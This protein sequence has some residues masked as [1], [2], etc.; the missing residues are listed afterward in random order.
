MHRQ[1]V[2]HLHQQAKH[3]DFETWQQPKESEWILLIKKYLPRLQSYRKR[4]RGVDLAKAL[5]SLLPDI[6]LTLDE[7]W[8]LARSVGIECIQP[9][10]LKNLLDKKPNPVAYDGFEPS[11]RMHI[12][13]ACPSHS[14][15]RLVELVLCV[16]DM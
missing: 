6:R 5:L 2:Q 8:E 13:Q 1:Q 16:Q 12:A 15:V 7:R 3:K 4:P 10:E 11:G 14:L 9:E